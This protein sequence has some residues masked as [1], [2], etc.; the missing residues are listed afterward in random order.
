MLCSL[1]SW[2]YDS[3]FDDYLE[4]ISGTNQKIFIYVGTA[5]GKQDN[6]DRADVSQFYI[7]ATMDYYQKLIEAG[8][9]PIDINIKLRVEARHTE[10]SWADN[11]SECLKF[12]SMDW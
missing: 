5:E 3:K 2:V 4:N 6:E 10:H 9:S 1:A 8:F 12:I 7:D 11:L